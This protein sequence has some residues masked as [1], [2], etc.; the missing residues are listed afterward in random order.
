[1][2]LADSRPFS[3]RFVRRRQHIGCTHPE[4]DPL[5]NAVHQVNQALF[6]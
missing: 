3:Q 6:M 4:V 2:V 5:A 1:M